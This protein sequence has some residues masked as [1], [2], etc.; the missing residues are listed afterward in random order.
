MNLS[1]TCLVRQAGPE[2]AA[3]YHFLDPGFFARFR[4]RAL[5]F[6]VEEFAANVR[7]ATVARCF[8]PHASLLP[9]TRDSAFLSFC[10]LNQ[11]AIAYPD[12][13]VG[14]TGG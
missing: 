12:L 4:L 13:E 6:D 7:T 5:R 8:L 3:A 11:R 2:T 14:Q 10:E 9:G 1:V